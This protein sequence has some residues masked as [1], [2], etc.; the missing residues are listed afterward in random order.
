[1]PY[2][3][4]STLCALSELLFTFSSFVSNL[5]C[6]KQGNHVF[7]QLPHQYLLGFDFIVMIRSI[8][9]LMM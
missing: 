7:S 9:E 1:M 8:D 3:A 2:P 6:Q 4:L 5:L